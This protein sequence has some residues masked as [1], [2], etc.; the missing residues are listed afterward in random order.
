MGKPGPKTNCVRMEVYLTVLEQTVHAI[1]TTPYLT[2]GNYGLLTPAHFIN[3][4]ITS[5]VVMKE[6]PESN[7]LELRKMRNILVIRWSW[8]TSRWRRSSAWRL[9]DGGRAMWGCPIFSHCNLSPELKAKLFK[10]AKPAFMNSI[11]IREMSLREWKTAGKQCKEP[12]TDKFWA[13]WVIIRGRRN[14]K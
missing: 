10:T 5:Q 6:L 12:V 9:T 8:S 14:K 2:Q 3:P 11:T 1:N 7:M 4:W 13:I